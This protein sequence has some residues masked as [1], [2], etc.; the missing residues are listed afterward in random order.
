MACRG[1]RY[2][3]V[4]LTETPCPSEHRLDLSPE[5]PNLKMKRKNIQPSARATLQPGDDGI[6]PHFLGASK[7]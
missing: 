1:Y 7:P 6:F 4:Q 2:S 5:T 3:I